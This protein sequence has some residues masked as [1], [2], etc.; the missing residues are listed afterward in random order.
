MQL[1]YDLDTG[2]WWGNFPLLH[3]LGFIHGVSSR[4]GGSSDAP[5][6]RMNLGLHVGDEALQVVNNRQQFCRA[7][8]IESADCITAEQIHGC[9][10]AVVAAEHR[11]L[12]M[13]DYG[14]AV[15]GVDA[16]ITDQAG[17]FLMLFFADCVPIMVVDPVRKACAAIHAGWKGSLA[18]IAAK[19]VQAMTISFGSRPADCWAFIAPA[20][21]ACCYQVSEQLAEQFRQTF[22]LWTGEFGKERQLDL[23]RLNQLQLAAAG[24]PVT[25]IQASGICTACNEMVFFSHRAHGGRTG[26]FSIVVGRK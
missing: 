6:E 26:R 24:I 5:Y 25:H 17:V 18:S 19:T 23:S 15:K 11:G 9:E 8:G 4:W 10:I 14:E 13:V 21:G 22:P 20:I 3:Q 2:V 16:L 7:V 1:S 12:G